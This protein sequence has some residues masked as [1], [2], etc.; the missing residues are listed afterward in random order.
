M[1]TIKDQYEI[2]ET[3]SEANTAI[4][5]L[6]NNDWEGVEYYYSLV[7]PGDLDEETGEMPVS[8]VYEIVNDNGKNAEHNVDFEDTIAEVL[9]DVVT[10]QMDDNVGRNN[11]Q[12]PDE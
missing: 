5:K 8:F 10:N 4:L 2:L 11:T 12:S 9:Y 3:S 7:M 1:A 6:Q